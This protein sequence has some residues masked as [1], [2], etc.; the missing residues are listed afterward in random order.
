[1]AVNK[2]IDLAPSSPTTHRFVLVLI[3]GRPSLLFHGKG[4]MEV[5]GRTDHRLLSRFA[6]PQC[7]SGFFFFMLPLAVW[8]F[9]PKNERCWRKL[10]LD[11][12][13]VYSFCLLVGVQ[14]AKTNHRKFFV[15]LSFFSLFCRWFMIGWIFFSCLFD[16]ENGVVSIST[17]QTRVHLKRW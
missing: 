11:A 14:E 9:A 12:E 10:R 7:A 15:W 1:M 3:L 5:P 6:K 17:T 13:N 4:C 2:V 8:D 16:T